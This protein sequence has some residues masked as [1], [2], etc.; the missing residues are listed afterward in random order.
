MHFHSPSSSI[1][2]GREDE[3]KEK[4]V[5]YVRYYYY[6]YYLC[7]YLPRLRL[8]NNHP[9]QCS[10]YTFVSHLPSLLRFHTSKFKMPMTCWLLVL[11]ELKSNKHTTSQATEYTTMCADTLYIQQSTK[12]QRWSGGRKSNRYLWNEIWKAKTWLQISLPEVPWS[13]Q[14]ESPTLLQLQ[15]QSG[16]SPSRPYSA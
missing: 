5:A 11:A 10:S 2:F 8:G 12:Q 15:S 7:H 16:P 4:K 14:T 3:K 1:V 6:D 13:S 9:Q